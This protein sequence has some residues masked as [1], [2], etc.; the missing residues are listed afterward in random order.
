MLASTFV[1]PSRAV[2]VTPYIAKPLGG[3]NPA[4]EETKTTDEPF[5]K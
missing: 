2:L 5:C 1:S 4:I 3:W